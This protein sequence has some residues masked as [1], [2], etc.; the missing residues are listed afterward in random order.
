MVPHPWNLD[1]DWCDGAIFR[2]DVPQP[3]DRVSVATGESFGR[4]C[5][6]RLSQIDV[7]RLCEFCDQRGHRPVA[8]R[9]A[10]AWHESVEQCFWARRNFSSL[11]TLRCGPSAAFTRKRMP[12]LVNCFAA[13]VPFFWNTLAGDAL[14]AGILFGGFALAEKDAACAAAAGGSRDRC[15]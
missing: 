5:I 11:P 15:P 8:W 10:T 3:L 6:C 9:Q 2:R 14:Y 1:A 4:R 13:G 12:G 7:H